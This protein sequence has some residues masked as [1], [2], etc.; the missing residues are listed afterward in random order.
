MPLAT[1]AERIIAVQDVSQRLKS[2]TQEGDAPKNDGTFDGTFLNRNREI[3][4]P[5]GLR[6]TV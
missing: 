3:Q 2:A 1:T 6:G 5:C 4:Y